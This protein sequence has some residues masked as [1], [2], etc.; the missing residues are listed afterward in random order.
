MSAFF[1]FFLLYNVLTTL[2]ISISCFTDAYT[3]EFSQ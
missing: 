2:V 3:G 1:F